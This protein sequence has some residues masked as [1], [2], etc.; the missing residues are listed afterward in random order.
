MTHSSQPCNF[1]TRSIRIGLGIAFFAG[2]LLSALATPARAEYFSGI[3]FDFTHDDNLPRAPDGSEIGGNSGEL[4]VWRGFHWQLADYTGLDLTG[5]LARRQFN[6]PAALSTTRIEGS[7][8]LRHKFGLGADVPELQLGAS[9]ARNSA[10]D[11]RRD[12]WRYQ[13][14]AGV[15]QR[16]S[17]QWSWNATASYE[18]QD[19]DLDD[20]R[21]LPPPLPNLPG[22]VWDLRAWQLALGI[23]WDVGA[24]WWLNATLTHRHGDIVSSVVP[25]TPILFVSHAVTIDPVFGDTMVAYRLAATTH[26]LALDWNHVVSDD[27][28]VYVGVERQFSHASGAM[29][30]GT[31]M[32]RAGFIHNF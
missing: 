19:G 20:P 32:V 22:N 11:A 25:P 15:K 28:T 29:S 4:A 16:L 10:N 7:A 26:T 18:R 23:E 1:S 14:S 24:T 27:S 21:V 6:Q 5:T 17:E 31:G 13:L 3:S 8:M 9:I 2:A 30:Y 12:A